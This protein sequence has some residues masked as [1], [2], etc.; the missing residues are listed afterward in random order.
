MP[1]KTF[2]SFRGED[3]FLVWSLRNL[4]EF[5]NV[6]FEMDDVSLRN[7]INSR[8]DTYIRSI[9]RPKIKSSDNCLCLI[10]ENT[11][12]SRKWVPWEIELAAEEGKR[13]VAMRFRSTPNATTPAVLT[14]LGIR[15]FNWDL[16]R[17]AR[18]LA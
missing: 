15:P 5:R 10:G 8:D 6:S 13:I 14:R 1:R 9:I 11:H 12:R 18:E 7:A 17:L 3:E 16:E 2:I 4:A